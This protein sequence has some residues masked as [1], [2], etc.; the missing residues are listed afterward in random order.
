MRRFFVEPQLLRGSTGVI[1][2]ELFRHMST[3]LRLKPG[4]S[5]LL[6]DGAGKEAIATITVVQKES[7]EVTLEP[8][9]PV[10]DTAEP[11]QITVYQGMPKGDKL[12]LI[13]QKCTE[14]GVTKIVPFMAA[15]S[16]PKL[17]GERLDKKLS[18]WQKIAMEAARQS[19]R[20]TVP[21]TG[22]M[23]SMDE[24]LRNSNESLRLLLWEGEEEQGLK[25]VLATSSCTGEIAV[26]IGPEGGLT[27][28][29]ADRAMATGYQS[30]NLGRRILRTETAGL[31]IVS[32]LQY[33]WGDLG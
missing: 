2:G 5:I 8:A 26:I 30:V 11:L 1:T 29:E 16:V 21:E 4:D 7:I 20:G 12:E 31:A 32:I 24:V 10:P 14:L 27:G 18:R 33:L 9:P 6:A 15:R 25:S 28:E 3:V 23:E 19:G 13:I 17:S 22:F